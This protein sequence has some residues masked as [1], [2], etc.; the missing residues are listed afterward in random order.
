VPARSAGLL[1][2]R[3]TYEG[4]IEVLIVHPGGPLWA[5]RDDGAW[6]V[7]K[8]EYAPGEE[9]ESAA[10]REFAEELGQVAPPGPRLDLG[11]LR[12][13]SGKLVRVWA[14][15]GDLDTASVVSNEFEMEWPPRSGKR[16]RWPEVDRAAWMPVE[17]A[18]RK[19]V[20]A[21]V[22]FVDRLVELLASSTE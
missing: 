7:A 20:K 10:E 21:Q 11:E 4:I 22:G 9:P 14:F 16:A 1:P 13:A 19:L 2:Y 15:E 5:A 8:G 18:R 17:Q 3:F 6:S 12:Q